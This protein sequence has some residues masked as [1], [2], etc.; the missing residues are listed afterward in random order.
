METWR[1]KI[2]LQHFAASIAVSIAASIAVSRCRLE[3]NS[4]CGTLILM[5]RTLIGILCGGLFHLR[6]SEFF[7]VSSLLYLLPAS[8]SPLLFSEFF[9]LLA[10][11]SQL[12]ASSSLLPAPCFPLLFSEFFEVSAFLCPSAVIPLIRKKIRKM[13]QNGPKWTKV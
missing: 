6:F 4:G 8:C 9:S 5:L 13:D 12:P 7:E 10:P 11:S 1:R 2:S 3:I